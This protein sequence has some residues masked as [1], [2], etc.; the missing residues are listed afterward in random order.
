MRITLIDTKRFQ[1]P[2]LLVLLL[3]APAWI[4]YAQQD[5]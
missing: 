1:L 4:S 2:V 3:S 5:C